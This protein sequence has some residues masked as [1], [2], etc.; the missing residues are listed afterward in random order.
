MQIEGLFELLL[1]FGALGATI[2]LIGTAAYFTTE[3]RN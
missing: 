3:D 2:G 1:F